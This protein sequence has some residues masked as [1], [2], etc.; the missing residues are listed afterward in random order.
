MNTKSACYKDL[1]VQVNTSYCNPKSRPATGS[2]PCNTQPCPARLDPMLYQMLPVMHTHL[3]MLSLNLKGVLVVISS[4]FVEKS[5]LNILID[6]LWLENIQSLSNLS[7]LCFELAFNLDIIMNGIW[8]VETF[9]HIF[10]LHFGGEKA[11]YLVLLDFLTSEYVNY[12]IV[13]LACPERAIKCT[14]HMLCCISS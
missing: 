9:P 3:N 7:S 5:K 1:R 4:V 11:E 14:V 13:Q 6:H 8:T 12:L 2:M 10:L